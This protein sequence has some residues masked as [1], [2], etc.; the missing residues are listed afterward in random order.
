MRRLKPENELSE[1]QKKQRE[2]FKK[3]PEA[4]QKMK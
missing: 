3:N 2:Y 4:H 1:G